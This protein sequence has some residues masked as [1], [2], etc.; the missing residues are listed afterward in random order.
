MYS[1]IVTKLAPAT[2]TRHVGH[3]PSV[4]Q[5]RDRATCGR[6]SKN[7]LQASKS[8]KELFGCILWNL[9]EIL[10]GIQYNGVMLRYWFT[11][12]RMGSADVS[13]GDL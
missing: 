10:A 9:S 5:D 6:D 11:E 3:G 13:V 1:E 8:L 4:T 7:A 12:W 2:A